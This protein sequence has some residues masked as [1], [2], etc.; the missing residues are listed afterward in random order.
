MTYMGEPYDAV[1]YNGPTDGTPWVQT[2][3]PDFLSQQSLQLK[4]KSE[5]TIP[6]GS[7]MDVLHESVRQMGLD[8]RNVPSG[9]KVKSWAKA[10][11]RDIRLAMDCAEQ[12]ADRIKA[13]FVEDAVRGCYVVAEG[14]GTAESVY[15]LTFEQRPDQ[16]LLWT[17]GE[18][19]EVPV[20]LP[21]FVREQPEIMALVEE[22]LQ[23]RRAAGLPLDRAL[24]KL[25]VVIDGT[26]FCPIHETVPMGML[27][28]GKTL[29]CK[30]PGCKMKLVRKTKQETS[31]EEQQ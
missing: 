5:G 22:G 1:L 6:S 16:I 3:V 17:S 8:S 9:Q 20:L 4:P 10:E 30:S 2:N 18:L 19:F 7:H 25:P 21:E 15:R 31:I 23:I 11:M 28:D 13:D 29:R 24:P 26:P 27:K 12:A 14:R